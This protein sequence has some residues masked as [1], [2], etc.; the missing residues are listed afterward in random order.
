M[1]IL[2]FSTSV[3]KFRQVRKLARTLNNIAGKG[4]WN[5]ALDDRDR[6]LRMNTARANS[7]AAISALQQQGY[8][9]H[10]LLD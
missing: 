7:N 2:V 1:E 4:N 10:E 8:R 5:F 9:C 3:R 6:I